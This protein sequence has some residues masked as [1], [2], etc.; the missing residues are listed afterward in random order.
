MLCDT[1]IDTELLSGAAVVGV[2]VT[3][4]IGREVL[5]IGAAVN[6]ALIDPM[7]AFV[8]GPAGIATIG[9]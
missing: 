8:L 9:T 1:S 6:T 2:K 4:S 5:T 3:G 7:G